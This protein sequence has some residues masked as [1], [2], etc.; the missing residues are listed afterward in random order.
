[1][2]PVVCLVGPSG[3]GKTSY[4]R[5]LIAEAHFRAPIVFTTRQRRIGDDAHLRFIEDRTFAAMAIRGL[6]L[7]HDAY[8][9]YRYGT[10]LEDFLM[11]LC[12]VATEGV[13]LDVTPS[14]AVQVRQRWPATQIV[15]LVPDDFRWLRRRLESRAADHRAIIDQRM[16]L[17][18]AYLDAVRSLAA[19]VIV[20]REHPD[21]WADTF[22][23]IRS[24]IRGG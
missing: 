13:V 11:C 6:F 20:C 2:K 3:V 12:D 4:V 15:A 5:R 7:E 14:G 9:G 1:M 19:P 23:E 16:L 24:L 10:S 8:C 22:V 18:H 21:T 17:L